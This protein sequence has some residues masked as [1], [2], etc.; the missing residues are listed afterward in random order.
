[1]AQLLYFNVVPCSLYGCT[2][3]HLSSTAQHARTHTETRQQRHA[4]SAC[5]ARPLRR[6]SDPWMELICSIS[7]KVRRLDEPHRPSHRL[8]ALGSLGSSQ[9]RTRMRFAVGALGE[10]MDTSRMPWPLATMTRPDAAMFNA[11]HTADIAV[12]TFTC[13][14]SV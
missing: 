9:P 3:N 2:C 11:A 8:L 13:H 14:Y 5:F 4:L 12:V 1:M 10:G 6:T 7:S